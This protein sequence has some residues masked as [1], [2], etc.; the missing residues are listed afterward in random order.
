MNTTKA[1]QASRYRSIQVLLLVFSLIFMTIIAYG[2]FHLLVSL[3]YFLAF[4]GALVIAVFAWYLARVVGTSPGGLRG[5][6]VLFIPLAVVSAAGVYNSLMLYMEGNRIVADT[7]VESQERFTALETAADAKLRESGATARVNRVNT[8]AEALYSE[9]RN[10]VNCGQGP[11]ARRHIETLQRELPGFA[12][13]SNPGQSC[14]RNEDLLNDYRQRIAGLLARADW[15]NPVLNDLLT[16]SRQARNTLDQL[17]A[18]VTTNYAPAMLQRTLS[19][20]EEQDAA[21][22]D[23]RHR[24]SQQVDVRDVP[25]GLH[26]SEVQSLG[27][28]AKLPGLFIERLDQPATYVYLLVALGFDLLMV[29]LFE[30]AAANGRRRAPSTAN[31]LGGAW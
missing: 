31:S 11:E 6:L 30:M 26:L 12:P 10:P 13:L 3:G 16:R 5:N 25:E 20:L 7:V 23:L 4:T 22:R 19:T 9:I 27:N 28:A 15:N 21:Y 17:R 14:S 8:A 2:Y 29:H 24:L 18:S 1:E